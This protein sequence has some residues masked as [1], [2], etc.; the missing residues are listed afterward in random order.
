V[1]GYGLDLR[2]TELVVLSACATGRGHVVRGEG[3]QGLRQAFRLAGARTLVTSLWRV[4]DAA[5]APLMGEFYAN[6]WGK[7][8]PKGEA[9]RQAQLTLLR[10]PPAARRRRPAARDLNLEESRPLPE[11][12]RIGGRAHPLVWAGFVLSGDSR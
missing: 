7:R 4:D 5:A 8:L 10:H 11:G 3:V 2:G 9:L 12:G 1:S 6:L